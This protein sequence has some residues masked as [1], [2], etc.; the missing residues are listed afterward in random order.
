MMS[1]LVTEILSLVEYMPKMCQNNN[2]KFTLMLY[3]LLFYVT[4]NFN[5]NKKSSLLCNFDINKASEN[6]RNV[7]IY[8]PRFD[9]IK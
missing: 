9:E 8:R 1:L 2:N 5:L 7:Q 6:H 3:S 4:A